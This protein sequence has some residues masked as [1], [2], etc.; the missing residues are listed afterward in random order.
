[1]SFIDYQSPIVIQKRTKFLQTMGGVCQQVIVITDLDENLRAS[2]FLQVLMIPA[3]AS[4]RASF[5]ANFGDAHLPT[6]KSTKAGYGVQ[7]IISTKGKQ[8]FE[9][10]RILILIFDRFQ[11]LRKPGVTDKTLF[12]FSYD[13][14][15][16]FGD[17]TVLQKN[18]G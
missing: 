13:C 16:G 6:V 9:L 17:N 12:S 18:P 14:P 7:I 11:S 3:G 1:M 2:G 8:C 4:Q 15:D 10:F 5:L